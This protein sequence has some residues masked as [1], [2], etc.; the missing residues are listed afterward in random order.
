[1]TWAPGTYLVATAQGP[2]EVEGLTLAGLGLRRIDVAPAAPEVWGLTHLRS[3][4]LVCR[5]VGAI[6]EVL[7][8]AGALAAAGDWTFSDLRQPWEQPMLAGMAICTA[9][10]GRCLWGGPGRPDPMLAGEIARRAA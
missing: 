3:G 7:P 5:L 9:H 4:H 10:P 6:D 8:I 2:V 1:M